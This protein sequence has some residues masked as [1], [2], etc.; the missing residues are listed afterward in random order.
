MER[1]STK[2][3]FDN[4]EQH[5]Y[6]FVTQQNK[7]KQRAK[8]PKTT[9][10]EYDAQVQKINRSGPLAPNDADATKENINGIC[11]KWKR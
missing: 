4:A 5:L 7:L 1:A 10:A 8:K 9:P 2:R 3:S 6:N 11:R